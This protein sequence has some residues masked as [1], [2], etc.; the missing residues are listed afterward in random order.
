MDRC[1][2]LDDL[3]VCSELRGDHAETSDEAHNPSGVSVEKHNNNFVVRNDVLV[4]EVCKS[5][6]DV[7][8]V[9]NLTRG[10]PQYLP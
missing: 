10:S 3:A 8:I 9:K 5:R 2:S 4:L 1:D 6:T 7:V